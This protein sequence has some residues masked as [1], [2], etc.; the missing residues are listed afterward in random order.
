MEYENFRTSVRNTEKPS[1][2][3]EEQYISSLVT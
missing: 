1:Y 3:E 2:F